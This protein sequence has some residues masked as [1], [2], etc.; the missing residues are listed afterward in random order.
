MDLAYDSFFL[1]AVV[2]YKSLMVLLLLAGN[3]DNEATVKREESVHNVNDIQLYVPIQHK[4]QD[5]RLLHLGLRGSLLKGSPI[6]Q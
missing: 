3:Y 4:G 1:D 5:P 2:E 6:A